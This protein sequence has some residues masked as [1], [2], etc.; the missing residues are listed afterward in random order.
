MSL[1][2]QEFLYNPMNNENTIKAH[3][4]VYQSVDIDKENSKPTCEPKNV[5]FREIIDKPRKEAENIITL[6]KKQIKQN[7]QTRRKDDHPN[8]F[9]LQRNKRMRENLE[10]RKRVLKKRFLEKMICF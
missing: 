4:Q 10:K 9:D 2:V 8:H 1:D 7:L 3:H 6:Q 5:T